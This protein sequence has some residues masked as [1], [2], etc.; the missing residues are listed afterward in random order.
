MRSPTCTA[1]AVEARRRL[2]AHGPGHA[3]QSGNFRNPARRTRADAVVAARHLRDR[4]G[5]PPAA[6][7][8]ASPAARP[9]A[10]AR[11]AR[12]RRRCLPASG[13]GAADALRATLQG[14]RR[15][16]AH[17]R[18]HRA[19]KR[20][21]ARSVG[22]A[23]HAGA[24]ARRS[25]RS[26]RRS[27]ARACSELA[28]RLRGRSDAV[29]TLLAR[30]ILAEPAAVRA[31]RRRHRRRLRRRAGRTARDPEQL[32]RSSCSTLEARERARTGIANLKVEYN[33]VHGFYIE[34]THA[35]CRKG[36]RR[37][38]PAPDAEECRAL[39]HAGTEDL[40]GQGAV[41][42]GARAGAR[43]AALRPVAR[44]SCAR[45]FRRCSASP[46]AL[47]EL[48]LLATFAE[49]AQT[50]DW[51]APEFIDEPLIEIEAGRHPVVEAQV[52]QFIANDT[53][54]SPARQL[55]LITG[56]NMGG[57]STYMRQVALIVL[58]AHCG[59]FVPA[60]ARAHR[61]GRPD[62]HPHRRRRRSRRRPLH[63]HG[64]DDR[65]RQHPAPR[66]ARQAWC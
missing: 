65:G 17:H 63:L 31:R 51:C 44:R 10:L 27:T 61:P 34:V 47:A 43:K 54:L 38:P 33:R 23:R 5:Q 26:S 57:K 52:D 60:Q 9:R 8:A 3:A 45:I 32:R 46:R 14:M 24:A 36:P 16:G 64:G 19:E 18:A 39:H 58:L 48:D 21:A 2:R 56:P 55:L 30:A 29:H 49:R 42:A 13:A 66:H 6:P 37:L 4:H 62:L 11:A 53:Q 1:L 7:H 40:R 28:Q 25:A 59:S 12:R 22:T 50:L 35:Q 41:G 20:A 15:C